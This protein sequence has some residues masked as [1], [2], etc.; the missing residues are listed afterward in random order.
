MYRSGGGFTVVKIVG[1]ELHTISCFSYSTCRLTTIEKIIIL[2][3]LLKS[4]STKV[5]NR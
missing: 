2:Y 4:R 3:Y 1:D 5:Q